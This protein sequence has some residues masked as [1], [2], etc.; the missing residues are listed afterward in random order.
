MRLRNL[1]I[2]LITTL[3][4]KQMRKF[5]SQGQA[6]RFLGCHR[7]V[8]NLFIFGHHFFKAKH[9]RAFSEGSFSEWN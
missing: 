8:N 4:E 3:Q 7:V 1:Q 9:Y 6:Q 5:K 2:Y